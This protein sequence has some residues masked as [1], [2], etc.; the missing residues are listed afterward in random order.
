MEILK[1]HKD[2]DLLTK[3]LETDLDDE[4]RKDI[5]ELL[6]AANKERDYA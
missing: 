6:E 4:T 2:I 1:Y 3:L 5:L